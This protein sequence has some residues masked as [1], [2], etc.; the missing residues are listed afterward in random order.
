LSDGQ[1][2]RGC[3]DRSGGEKRLLSARIAVGESHSFIDVIRE[4]EPIP[5]QGQ[6]SRRS[7]DKEPDIQAASRAQAT[8][9]NCMPS[10]ERHEAPIPRSPLTELRDTLTLNFGVCGIIDSTEKPQPASLVVD[11]YPGARPHFSQISFCVWR[12]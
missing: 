11:A 1:E 12:L 6:D 5:K 10:P 7:T 9:C 8:A 4:E 2:S 3:C